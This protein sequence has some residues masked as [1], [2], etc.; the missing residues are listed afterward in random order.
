MELQQ[1]W[2]AVRER[3]HGFILRRINDRQDA[4]DV[5]HDVLIKMHGN[6]DSLKNHDRAEAWAYQITRNGIADYYRRRQAQSITTD[7]LDDFDLLPTSVDSPSLEREIATCLRPM[8]DQLPEHY[9]EAVVLADLEGVTQR[10]VADR[11][12]ISVSGAKSRVQ[13]GRD[14][15]REILHECC[16]FEHDRLG[17]IIDA[18]PRCSDCDP[19]AN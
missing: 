9:R 11:L 6:L 2:N 4:E 1:D 16:V 13:R 15:L 19:C 10:E 18:H 14:R 12:G 7:S 8:I 3:L 5:L 17:S